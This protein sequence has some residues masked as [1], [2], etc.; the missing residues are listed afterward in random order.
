MFQAKKRKGAPE[1]EDECVIR[2][3]APALQADFLLEKLRILNPTLSTIELVERSIPGIMS[4]LVSFNFSEK[5]LVDTSTWESPKRDAAE[6][7]SFL[8]SRTTLTVVH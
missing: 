5:L 8:E 6:L 1:S 7:P 2:W 3:Q 4:F